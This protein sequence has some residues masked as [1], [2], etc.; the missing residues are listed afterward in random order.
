MVLQ[1]I[2]DSHIKRGG[3]RLDDGGAAQYSFENRK[4][5]LLVARAVMKEEMNPPILLIH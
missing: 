3:L 5:Y 1:F 2:N 4:T